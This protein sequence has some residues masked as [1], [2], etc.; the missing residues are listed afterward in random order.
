MPIFFVPGI[1][2]PGGSKRGFI[3]RRKSGK[4]G[5]AMADTNP[6]AKS[7]RQD[8]AFAAAEHF[9]KPIEGPIEFSF[10][11][12]MLR[13]KGHFEKK[14]LRAGAPAFPTTRPDCTKLTRSTEDALKGIAWGDDSQVVA[15]MA[16]KKFSAQPR[17]EITVEFLE[18][19]P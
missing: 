9:P 16:T 13:P 18:E 4:Q 3:I 11:F 1:P 8:V 5:I 10:E 2:Q 19:C 15:L 12:Q 17:A 7:W 14:G 6:K